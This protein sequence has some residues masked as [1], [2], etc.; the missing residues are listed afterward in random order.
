MVVD[1]RIEKRARELYVA[2]KGYDRWNDPC[3]PVY[4][5][6]SYRVRAAQ[7]LQQSD[8]N[9][10]DIKDKGMKAGTKARLFIVIGACLLLLTALGYNAGWWL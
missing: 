9:S 10:E 1:K 6:M 2:E 3:E 8:K 4:I 7:E 5:K